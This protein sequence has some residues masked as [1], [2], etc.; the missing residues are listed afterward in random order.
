MATASTFCKISNLLFCAIDLVKCFPVER[1]L[2]TVSTTI[3]SSDSAESSKFPQEKC[4]ID[5][6]CKFLCIQL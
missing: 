4:K 1:S 2:F 6:I 5:I 3:T